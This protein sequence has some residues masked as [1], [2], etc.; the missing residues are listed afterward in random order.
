[1][2]TSPT[3]KP[4]LGSNKG[5][6]KGKALARLRSLKGDTNEESQSSG[7]DIAGLTDRGFR[8]VRTLTEKMRLLSWV[9][10]TSCT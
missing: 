9:Y 5:K 1:M 3:K 10:F 4:R 2:E 7:G 8:D 6:K